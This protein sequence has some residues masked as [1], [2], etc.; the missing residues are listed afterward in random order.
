MI[1]S[2]CIEAFDFI[3]NSDDG[4]NYILG[5]KL[6]KIGSFYTDPLPPTVL[7]I[8]VVNVQDSIIEAWEISEIESKLLRLPYKNQFVTFP[9]LHTVGIFQQIKQKICWSVSFF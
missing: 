4:Q 8:N 3:E 1:K 9:I 2:D 6:A 5:K 7:N